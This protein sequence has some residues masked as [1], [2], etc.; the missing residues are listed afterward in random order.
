MVIITIKFEHNGYLQLH[1]TNII[2]HDQ[3]LQQNRT[4]KFKLEQKPNEIQNKSNHQ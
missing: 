2:L 1:I 4:L 3:M